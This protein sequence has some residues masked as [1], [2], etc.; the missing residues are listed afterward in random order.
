MSGSRTQSPAVVL[1][2]ED[3]SFVRMTAADML[4][5]AGFTVIEA[6]NADV[7]WSVLEHRDD[8]G[9]LFTDIDMPGSM[10]GFVLAA[11]VAERWPHIRLV[12]TSGRCRPRQGDVPDHGRFVPKPYLMSQVLDAFEQASS[13]R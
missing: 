13:S 11:R 1:L 12:V 6:A 9:V 7:A 5:D 3:E 4:D 2:V 10:D 8:V